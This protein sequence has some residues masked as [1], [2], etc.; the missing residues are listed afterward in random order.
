DSHAGPPIG[1]R[2][3]RRCGRRRRSMMSSVTKVEAT[4]TTPNLSRCCE[5]T[6]GYSVHDHVT[7]VFPAHLRPSWEVT[8][9]STTLRRRALTR[10]VLFCLVASPISVRA[11]DQA[12]TAPVQRLYD[13]LLAVMKAGHAVPFAQR[14]DQLASTIDAVFD[15]P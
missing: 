6:G 4:G 14:Y 3:A 8:M 12:V 2:R 15:L 5:H 11:A 13:S 10:L 1:C 7:G 9:P